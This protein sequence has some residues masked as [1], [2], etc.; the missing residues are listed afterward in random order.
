MKKIFKVTTTLL[1]QSFAQMLAYRL[2][3][4]FIVIF[5]MLFVAS[6]LISVLIYFNFKPTI[7]GW[8]VY[9]FIIL[10]ATSN[11]IL[12]LYQFFFIV[13]HERLIEKILEGELDFDLIRPID[14]Q[15][16]LSIRYFDYPSLINLSIP[17]F[18]LYYGISRSNLDIS[19]IQMLLYGFFL[20][21]GLSFYYLLN[22]F[23]FS[24]SFWIEKSQKLSGAPEYLFDFATRPRSVYP[25]GI[26]IILGGFIPIILCTNVPVQVL[27]DQSTLGMIGA[28]CMSTL[29][30]FI[31]VRIQWNMGIKRYSSAS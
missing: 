28:L 15:F 17:L 2:S 30:L 27:R 23:F 19:L 8:D 25:S 6:E 20:I 16:I 13:S 26:Q 3:A 4:L 1:M 7:N 24:L 11:I 29:V 22:Q 18:L 14:S 12:Y 9:S 31:I 21:I 10:I 5:G